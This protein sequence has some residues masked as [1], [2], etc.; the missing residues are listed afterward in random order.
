M[1]Y[2]QTNL[3]ADFSVHVLRS[4]FSPSMVIPS[5]L[6]LKLSVIVI[7]TLIFPDEICCSG[8]MTILGLSSSI[9][10]D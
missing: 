5:G 8:D 9:V 1:V 7:V 3:L 10:I 2:E 6:S 4:S